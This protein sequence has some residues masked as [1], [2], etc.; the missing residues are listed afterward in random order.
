MIVRTTLKEVMSRPLT[1]EQTAQLKALE[2]IEPVP[3]EDC[4]AYSYE[5]LKEMKRRT[6]ERRAAENAE[7]SV[8]ISLSPD[9]MRKARSLGAGYPAI[10]SRLVENALNDP[11]LLRKSM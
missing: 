10:L 9:S 3:D 2:D 11:E 1:E 6:D 5:E 4:P 7:R 8:T